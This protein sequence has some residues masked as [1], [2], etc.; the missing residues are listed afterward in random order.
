MFEYIKG[1]IKEL[2]PTYLVLDNGNIG[3]FIEISI[4]TYTSLKEGDSILVFIHQ[5]IRED[6]NKLYGFINKK[7]REIFRLLISVSG[8]GPNTARMMLSS[9]IPNE[10]EQAIATGNVALL[11]SIKGVG[12]KTAQRII[13]DL[14]DKIGKISGA[15]NI[16]IDENNTLKNEAL[17]ALVM[18]GFV[19]N[20]VMKVLD[21]LF[22]E[23]K[24]QAVE[25]VVKEALKRL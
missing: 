16:F 7:E 12:A 17:S 13:V 9:M 10:I 6:A 1:I 19:K 4:N 3:Y 8:I 23:N 5:I 15:E 20:S 21:K 24:Y 25:D 11:Q 14:R 18:L 2:K 22:A